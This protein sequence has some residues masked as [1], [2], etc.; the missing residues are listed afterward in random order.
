MGKDILDIKDVCECNRCL[1][2]KTLHPQASLINLENPN[3]E[4]DFVKFEFYA[5]LLIEDCKDNC[6]CCGR[7]HYDFSHATMVFLTPGEAFRMSVENMLP[8][9][10]LLLAFH[11]NLLFR[12]TL[13][14]HIDSYT[15]FFY[16]KEEALHLSQREKAIVTRCFDGIERELR[17]DIDSH[18]STL[19]SRLIEL[20]LDYCS[21]FYERQFITREEKNKII[22][23]EFKHLI[24][25]YIASGRMADGVF[26]T[27]DYCARPLNLSPTYFKDLLKFETGK[28]LE[29]Y[30]QTK[31]MEAARQMMLKEENTPAF[32][33]RWLGFTDTS[34]FNYI[35]KKATGTDPGEFQHPQ[36]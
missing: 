16:R 28:T 22:L 33:A 31:R 11:P 30:I 19:I 7:N 21:R 35:F 5:I 32:I 9:K 4:Q 14:N 34:Q 1:C 17:H 3:F 26:P 8:D 27:T 2:S 18:S 12:T 13:N 29:E 15:F 25:D 36:N 23:K 20:L 6:N 24:D 10:G